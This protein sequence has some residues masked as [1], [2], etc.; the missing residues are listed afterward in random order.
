MRRREKKM[1]PEEIEAWAAKMAGISVECGE[2]GPI[3][4]LAMMP[5]ENRLGC[6]CY[7]TAPDCPLGGSRGTAP[8]KVKKSV[9][10]GVHTPDGPT[11][12]KNSPLLQS[13]TSQPGGATP[14]P[15][16]E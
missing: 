16:D 2:Y 3:E 15:E 4:R 9:S 13:R 14:T 10:P 6:I 8:C 5:K 12:T 1:T 7:G 11:T